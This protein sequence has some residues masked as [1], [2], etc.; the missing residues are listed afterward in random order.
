MLTL[1]KIMTLCAMMCCAFGLYAVIPLPE[2]IAVKQDTMPF[3]MTEETLL[4]TDPA[5][6][7]EATL[8]AQEMSRSTGFSLPV[9]EEVL[10]AEIETTEETEKEEALAQ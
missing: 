7:A 6:R 3:V 2:S 5:F 1:K 10:E 9:S 8:A 4:I